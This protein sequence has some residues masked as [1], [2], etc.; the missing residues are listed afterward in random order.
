MAPTTQEASAAKDGNSA[1]PSDATAGAQLAAAKADH[2]SKEYM[3]LEKASVSPDF[4]SALQRLIERENRGEIIRNGDPDLDWKIVR[5]AMTRDE[6]TDPAKS[7]RLALTVLK[8]TRND[9]DRYESTWMPFMKMWSGSV[10][11]AMRP[12]P[13]SFSPRVSVRIFPR[14]SAKR[15]A[16]S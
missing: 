8:N 6:E 5:D 9:T 1:S 2:A 16:P 14:R 7:A 13:S 10:K 15:P 12:K 4:D 11:K 3:A